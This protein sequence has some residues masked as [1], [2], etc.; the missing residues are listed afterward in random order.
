M[1]FYVDFKEYGFVNMKNRHI[2][3]IRHFKAFS[4]L[5]RS[6]YRLCWCYPYFLAKDQTLTSKT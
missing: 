4:F 1:N 6:D 2:A 3:K 5:F